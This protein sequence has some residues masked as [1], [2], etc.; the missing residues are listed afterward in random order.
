MIEGYKVFKHDWTCRGFQYEVGKTFE[1]DVTPSCCNR[2]FHFCKKLNDCF[3]YYQF[4]PDNKVAKV[5]A[6]GEIDEEADGSKCCTNKIKIVEEM[7]W[8]DIYEMVNIGERNLGRCNTGLNNFGN[9]NSGKFNRG[10]YNSGDLNIGSYNSGDYNHGDKNSGNC[11]SGDN[12]T[13][14]HNTGNYN[15]GEWNK[16]NRANGCFNTNKPT[17]YFFNKPSKWTCEKWL[18]SNQRQ[19]LQGMPRKNDFVWVPSCVMTDEEKELHSEY[20]ITRGYF[21]VVDDTKCRQEWWD[22]LREIDKNSIK[23][24]PNFDKD[25][26]EEITG[27]KI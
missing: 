20:K 19:L 25:I 11:N 7:S 8:E 14:N 13:G 10:Y 23:S 15:T 26:F 24:L 1:E 4:N 12:N 17:L 6:L 16:T 27:I 22:E 3:K 18:F 21:R 2:G 9:Y 5:I